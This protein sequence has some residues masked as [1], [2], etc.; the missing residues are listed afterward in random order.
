VIDL[1]DASI[2]RLSLALA[3]LSSQEAPV[4]SLSQYIT[5]RKDKQVPNY[6]CSPQ[7]ILVYALCTFCL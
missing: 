4:F 2:H 3:Q 6:F 1:I 5:E 7:Q